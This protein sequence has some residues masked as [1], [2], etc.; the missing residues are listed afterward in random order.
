MGERFKQVRNALGLTQQAI[1]DELDCTIGVVTNI[2]YDRA[3]P[4]KFFVSSFCKRYHVN[5]HWLETGE[6]EMFISVSRDEIIAE[7]MMQVLSGPD[8]FKKAFISVMM[9][10]DDDGWA[11]VQKFAEDLTEQMKDQG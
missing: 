11:L 4:N 5:Q 7:R 2:E 3:K 6:G 1:A 9:Q 10:L 8:S